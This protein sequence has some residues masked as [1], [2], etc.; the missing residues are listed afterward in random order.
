MSIQL[1]HN[2]PMALADYSEYCPAPLFGPALHET[3]GQCHHYCDCVDIVKEFK[4]NADYDDYVMPEIHFNRPPITYGGDSYNFTT[5]GDFTSNNIIRFSNNIYI[6]LPNDLIIDYTATT[7]VG[8]TSNK[9]INKEECIGVGLWHEIKKFGEQYNYEIELEGID[10]LL[11]L[12]FTKEKLIQTVLDLVEVHPWENITSDMVLEV[13]GITK[14]SLYHH[15]VDF[16]ELIETV[17]VKRF[18]KWVDE[19]IN[20]LTD[21]MNRGK[22]RKDILD[23]LRDYT[24]YSQSFKRAPNRFERAETIALTRNNPRLLAQLSESQERLTRALTELFSTAQEKGI[25]KKE[26]DPKVIAVFVQAY[27]LGKI[28]DDINSDKMNPD[29]WVELIY[30]TFE[31]VILN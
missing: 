26:M 31:K 23:I 27:T 1:P 5:A 3:T 14:G 22:S 21:H 11:N 19:T 10:S 30:Q 2:C 25:V 16:S 20:T 28:I 18:S 8:N 29:N 24:T 7:K 12:T 17:R 9:F 6:N 15:F 4:P 13:S